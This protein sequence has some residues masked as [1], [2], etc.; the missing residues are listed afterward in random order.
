MYVREGKGETNAWRRGGVRGKEKG[1]ERK[2]FTRSK[3][4][5]GRHAW[6]S[7]A[8]GNAVHSGIIPDLQ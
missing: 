8:G 4:S 2:R 7:P 1:Q 3:R 6:N 5:L